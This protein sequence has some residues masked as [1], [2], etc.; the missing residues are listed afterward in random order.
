MNKAFNEWLKQ[1]DKL[2]FDKK[3]II[4]DIKIVESTSNPC[5]TVYH[6]SEKYIGQIS[7]WQSGAMYFEILEIEG[8]KTILQKH[9]EITNNIDFKSLL[10]EYIENMK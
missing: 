7:V 2:F 9:I 5:T 1:N 6:S 3:I 10:S 8:E 4:D